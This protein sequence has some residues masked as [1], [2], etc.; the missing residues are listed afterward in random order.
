MK[1]AP[2][3][4]WAHVLLVW[5]VANYI[6]RD[7]LNDDADLKDAAERFG[8]IPRWRAWVIVRAAIGAT[9]LA[10]IAPT[11]IAALMLIGAI[12]VPFVRVAIPAKRCA[13]LETLANVAFVAAS[14]ALVQ[15]GVRLEHAWF[16][17]P[18]T[19]NRISA[20]C[21][22]AALLFVTIHG[23]TNIVRGVLNKSGA[24]PTVGDP[25]NRVLVALATG[26]LAK[27]VLATCW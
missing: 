17:I 13:E 4:V 26:S 23:G 21:I 7:P 15:N 6:S 9:V 14:F 18:T 3:L 22:I 27:V 19:E 1:S 25:E 5:A 2:L 10:Y 20:M 12:A 11:G 8:S 16:A 24:V